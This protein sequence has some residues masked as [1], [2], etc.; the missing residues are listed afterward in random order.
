MFLNLV[1]VVDVF[2]SQKARLR[3]TT[4][5]IIPKIPKSADTI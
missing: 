5:L 4:L 1:I 3:Y 2:H